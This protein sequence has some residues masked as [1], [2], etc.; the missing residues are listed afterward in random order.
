MKKSYLAIALTMSIFQVNEVFSVKD[1]TLLSSE[2]STCNYQP[3][4]EVQSTDSYYY[5]DQPQSY[6]DDNQNY[7]TIYVDGTFSVYFMDTNVLATYYTNGAIQS[8][9]YLNGNVAI[10]DPLSNLSQYYTSLGYLSIV[11]P[12]LPEGIP[13]SY[14]L[15][16]HSDYLDRYDDVEGLNKSI[17]TN[18]ETINNNKRKRRDEKITMLLKK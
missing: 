7:V 8:N 1:G 14:P 4:Q 15:P 17:S 3:Y 18:K 9:Y 2:S 10:Y 6:Y 13:Y 12:G 5:N 11:K 16:Y